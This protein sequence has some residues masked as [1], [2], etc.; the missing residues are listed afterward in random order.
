MCGIT[1]FIDPKLSSNEAQ[2]LV[3]EMADCIAH[4]GPDARGYWSDMPVVFAHNRLAIIDLSAE[5]NQPMEYFDSVITYNGEIYNYIEVRN[6][7]QKKGYVFKTK[8]DTEVILAAYREYGESCVQHFMGMWAFA[9]WDKKEKILF[10]SRDRFGIKPF[11]YIHEG[12]RFYFAS[13]F[14]ALKRSPLF[15]NELNVAQVNRGLQLGWV[16][17]NDETYF[18]RIKALPAAHNLKLDI[19]SW[20]LVIQKY[21]NIDLTQRFKGSFEEKKEKF[22]QLFADSIKMHMRSDVE[23]GGCLSGG[24]DSS[25]IASG[26][27][28]FFPKTRF[29]TFT[30]YY[31]AQNEVDERPWVSRVLKKYPSL[32]PFYF[33]PTDEQIKASFDK[34][35]Y[36]ADIPVPGSSPFSQYFL[37]QLAADEKI[38]V[39]LDGQGSDEMLAGYMHSFYRMLGNNISSFRLY[40][41]AREILYLMFRQKYSPL[42][43]ADVK[44]KSLLTIF[45]S[46]QKLYELEYKKYYPFL[47]EDK[48]VNFSLENKEGTRLNKFLYHLMFTTSLPTL[49]QYED[50]NSMAFSIE[51]RV[52]FLD[53]R[54]VE[55]VFSLGDDDKIH[56]GW[57]KYILRESLSGILPQ[58]ITW[59]KDKKGFVTPGEQKWL[60]GPLKHLLDADFSAVNNILDRKKTEK[61]ISDFKNG[62]N[63]TANLVWRLAVLNYWLNKNL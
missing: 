43:I 3:V 46:E 54:L 41:Y 8:S 18:S 60:R 9:L 1:G 63:K 32:T 21:W 47:S 6:E 50:R 29:K 53:H 22:Y 23:V 39:V 35:I 13:D 58:E 20:K 62:E 34:F 48:S 11:Y 16:C 37:M 15:A 49:L 27:S 25:A 42:K 56:H 30:V 19:G 10:C 57:T 5:G 17:Y 59:R 38:K 24:L 36:H 33:T 28:S 52:P 12:D 44:L 14:K 40:K 61:L 7:L 51:S 31:R 26:V 4:R 45:M 2:R 55:F